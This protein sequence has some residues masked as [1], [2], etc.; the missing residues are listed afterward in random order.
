MHIFK[1][2][3][4]DFLRWRVHALVLSWIIILAGVAV[5]WSQVN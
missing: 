4:F 2:T 3:N 5:I 1:N